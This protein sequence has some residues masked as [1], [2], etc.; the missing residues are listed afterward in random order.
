MNIAFFQF[1]YGFIVVGQAETKCPKPRT[2]RDQT[3][4]VHNSS[5]LEGTLLRSKVQSHCAFYN[6]TVAAQHPCRL[7][8]TTIWPLKTWHSTCMTICESPDLKGGDLVWLLSSSQGGISVPH[9]SL[10]LQWAVPGCDFQ[11]QF[12][13]FSP[14]QFVWMGDRLPSNLFIL[15]FFFPQTVVTSLFIPQYR[16]VVR[17]G[18]QNSLFGLKDNMTSKMWDRAFSWKATKCTL[19]FIS[20]MD[21]L[22]RQHTIILSVQCSLAS[23]LMIWPINAPLFSLAMNSSR[24]QLL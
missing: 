9:L 10:E 18:F 6:L 17:T 12:Q 14:V 21:L 16:Y 4:E 23:V 8:L 7:D 15:V 24:E 2:L 3:C 11:V 13:C 19:V 22:F 20:L 5:I 1:F